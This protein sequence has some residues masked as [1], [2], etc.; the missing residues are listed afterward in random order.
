LDLQSGAHLYRINVNNAAATDPDAIGMSAV[1]AGSDASGNMCVSNQDTASAVFHTMNP[2]STTTNVAGSIGVPS[3]GL[4][5]PNTT[6]Q[7]N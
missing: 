3:E 5:A 7:V 2:P 4:V 6:E 1:G